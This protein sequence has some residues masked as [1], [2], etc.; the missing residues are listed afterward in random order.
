MPS[1]FC[2][3]FASS[4]PEIQEQISIGL[5][6]VG[7]N[8]VFFE[9]SK[10]KL[11][12]AGKLLPPQSYCYLK[13]TVRQISQL[14]EAENTKVGSLLLEPMNISNKFSIG[15]MEYLS[16]YSNNI[17]TFSN[18]KIFDLDADNALFEMLFKKYVDVFV[19]IT[20]VVPLK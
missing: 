14:V 16:R 17:L 18:P 19:T 20:G 1:H 2:I 12:I 5:L 13:D 9:I 3:L 11:K 8:S 4:R 15:Y 7:S 10:T 6:L